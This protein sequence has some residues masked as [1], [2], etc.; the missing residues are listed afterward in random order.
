MKRIV[1][2]AVVTVFGLSYVQTASAKSGGSSNHGSQHSSMQRCDRDRGDKDRGKDKDRCKDKTPPKHMGGSQTGPIGTP[3][4][5]FK[6]VKVTKDGFE[7]V[8]GH[9]ERARARQ[10][11][12]VDP[13]LVGPV[14]RDHRN[15]TLGGYHYNPTQYAPGGVTVTNT[16]GKGKGNITPTSGFAGTVRDHRGTG[17]NDVIGVG[18]SPVDTAINGLS[19]LGSAIGNGLSGLGNTI[20][21]DLAGLGNLFGL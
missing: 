1:T 21:N 7:F 10:Q 19:G 4:N 3:E 17:N 9:W 8:N 6:P 15:T 14:V 16:N 2:L 20:G 13:T 12:I 11:T 18:G 5:P